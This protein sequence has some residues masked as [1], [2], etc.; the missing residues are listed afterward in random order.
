MS[1]ARGGALRVV[2]D[3]NVLISAFTQPRGRVAPIWQAAR[4]R[5]YRLVVSPPLIAEAAGVLR[6]KFAWEQG[7]VIRRLKLLT[8]IGELVVPRITVEVITEDP[9]DNRILE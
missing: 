8:R 9:P 7:R 5:R 3:T 2:L 4:E 1:T 6:A